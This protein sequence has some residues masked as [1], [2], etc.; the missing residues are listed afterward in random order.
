MNQHTFEQADERLSVW[1]GEFPLIRKPV[2]RL[3][4]KL[5]STRRVDKSLLKSTGIRK[6]LTAVACAVLFLVAFAA[7]S[8]V[9]LGLSFLGSQLGQRARAFH[10]YGCQS[11]SC[12]ED[13]RRSGNQ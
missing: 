2:A 8:G 6:T 9:V 12:S 4:I 3:T 5:V 1:I 7:S 13:W 11:V 10:Q